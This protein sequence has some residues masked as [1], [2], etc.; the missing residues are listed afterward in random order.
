LL[1][2]SLATVNASLYLYLVSHLN[3]LGIPDLVLSTLFF[4]TSTF[5][6][7]WNLGYAF[8]IHRRSRRPKTAQNSTLES[9]PSVSIIVPVYRENT[10][11]LS[12]MVE[13]F[14]KLDYPA[15]M[16]DMYVCDDTDDPAQRAAASRVCLDKGGDR[17]HYCTRDSRRGFKAG[18]INDV[19]PRITSKYSIMLDVDHVPLPDMVRRLVSAK[20]NSQ[21]DFLMFP[22]YFR[23][24]E[25]NSVTVSSSLKQL[26]DY[27]IDRLGRCVTNS[28]FC[29]TTNWIVETESLRSLGGL[30]ESTV[31][32]DLA[33]GLIAH[34][35]G[36]KIDLIDEKLALGLA[37][38]TL[39]SWR[40]QQ[41]RWSSGTFKVAKTIYPKAWPRL[42]WHQRMDY[43]LS[44][45]WYLC[46]FFTFFLYLFP[47]STALGVKF[48][49]Y[50]SLPEF[51]SLTMSLI[52]LSWLLTSYPVYLESKSVRKTLVAQAASLALGD[53]Y[54][55]A[56]ISGLRRKKH[57]FTVTRKDSTGR[58]WAG[59]ALRSL[60]F[61]FFFVALGAAVALHSILTNQSLA[62]M[63]NVG[64]IWYNNL[65]VIISALI[66]GRN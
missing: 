4:L 2:L 15:S 35:K 58:L 12:A 42:T 23:N 55:R 50:G 20:L 37:P 40:R 18:A 34:S 10:S 31:T 1:G 63:V 45:S 33:T 54:V 41:Y 13:G 14:V 38:N 60:R 43:T 19:L 52:A 62:S 8:S 25:E 65:W 22:Q 21:A 24:E 59:S 48:F 7:T 26:V 28:A 5:F 16:L 36:F 32:E 47:I 51:L 17:V 53:V 29:V 46:G 56:F 49:R 44:I 6:L 57:L 11:V 27:R 30:D 9:F 64:W 3:W 61:H 39:E 66:L